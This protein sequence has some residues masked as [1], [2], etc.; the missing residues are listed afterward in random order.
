MPYASEEAQAAAS[1]AWYEANKALV[2]DR[3][4]ARIRAARDL[5]RLI[6]AESMTR[7]VSPAEIVESCK[8]VAS[9]YGMRNTDQIVDRLPPGAIGLGLLAGEV[10]FQLGDMEADELRLA[11]KKPWRRRIPIELFILNLQIQKIKRT[12]IWNRDKW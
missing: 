12:S 3:K 6:A 7:W 2:L 8:R 10:P 4:S 9:D 1:K 5:V 11:I